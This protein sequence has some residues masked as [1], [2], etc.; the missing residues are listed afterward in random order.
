MKVSVLALLGFLLSL[1]IL[2]AAETIID[3]NNDGKADQW[4]KME[5]DFVVNVEADRDFDGVIDYRAHYNGNREISYEE[6]D[7]NYDGQM[8]DFYF[9]D[10][11]GLLIR[12]EI[13]SNF[14][15]HVD[16]WVY[17]YEG[18]YIKRYERDTDFDGE[19]DFVKDFGAE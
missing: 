16:I 8:D 4:Y 14:D 19:I 15:E 1:S 7:F 10:E 12:Q 17:I 9:Y 3:S 6:F 5:G 2:S 18:M 13:D 11:E